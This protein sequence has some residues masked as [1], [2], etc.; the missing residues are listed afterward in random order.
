MRSKSEL[1]KLAKKHGTP[2]FIV[3]H[4][5]IRKNYAEFKRHLPRVQAYY[6]V[7]ANSDPAIVKTLFDAGASISGLTGWPSGPSGGSIGVGKSAARLYHLRGI[8]FSESWI[9]MF[10]MLGPVEERG[11]Y[12]SPVREA[13]ILEESR[14]VTEPF[15]CAAMRWP[16]GHKSARSRKAI[17]LYR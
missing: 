3:D 1:L 12:V 17:P 11:R 13:A 8:S 9:F 7:K 16:G 15:F 6:A 2:L 14:L 4:D 5:V 10:S